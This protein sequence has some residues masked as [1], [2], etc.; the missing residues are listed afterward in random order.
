MSRKIK[1]S[2]YAEYM[3]VTRQTALRW[4]QNGTLP[5]PAIRVSPKIVLVEVPD[6][7]TGQEIPSQKKGKTIGYAR[8]STAKQKDGLSHQKLSILEYA[9]KHDIH[10]DEIVEEIGSGFNENRRK[11]NKILSD[12]SVSTII[13][14]HKDRLARS[15][16]NIIRSALLSQNR[17]IIVIDDSELEDDLVKEITDFMVS[18]CG[19]IYGKRGAE[20]VKNQLHQTQHELDSG[21]SHV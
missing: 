7:F 13:V 12:D 14:E 8:V 21:D 1:L 15:N 5:H 4:F 20:R 10:V 16:F 11:I 6:D 9:N 17:E 19:R 3:N 2:K 18:A